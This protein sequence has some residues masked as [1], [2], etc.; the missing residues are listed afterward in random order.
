MGTDYFSINTDPNIED[1]SLAV[2]LGIPFFNLTGPPVDLGIVL[3]SSIAG[4]SSAVAH[5][6]VSSSAIVGKSL[7]AARGM[8]LS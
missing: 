5:S 8:V 3:S 7:A 6:I 4:K 2:F 1:W